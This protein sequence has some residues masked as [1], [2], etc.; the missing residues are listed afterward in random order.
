M[1]TKSAREKTSGWVAA[2]RAV[3]NDPNENATTLQ[4]FPPNKRCMP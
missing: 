3:T 4:G 1:P 2:D